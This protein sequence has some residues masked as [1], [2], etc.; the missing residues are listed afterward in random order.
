M[1]RLRLICLALF[2]L[3]LVAWRPPDQPIEQVIVIG[4]STDQAAAAVR[5]AQGTVER[6]LRIIDGVAWIDVGDVRANV[7]ETQLAYVLRRM[8]HQL[9]E[10][11]GCGHG[12]VAILQIGDPI[13]P[14]GAP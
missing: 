11:R 7:I 8:Q 9:Q 13:G 14:R 2:A 1:K 5:A 4:H 3:A 12:L 6:D 10:G